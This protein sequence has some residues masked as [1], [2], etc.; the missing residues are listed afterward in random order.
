VRITA[1]LINAS[2]GYHLWSATY[3]R[4]LSDILSVQDD[5]ARAITGALTHELEDGGHVP[6]PHTRRKIDPAVY[7]L[8]LQG[9]TAFASGN[10]WQKAYTLFKEV[11]RKQP[12]FAPAY[13][14]LADS[15]W[16]FTLLDP[17]HTNAY[18]AEARS[19]AQTA[20]R[21]DPRNVMARGALLDVELDSWNWSKAAEY[22]S[23]LRNTNPDNA[24][25]AAFLRHYYE[26]MGF[27]D[28][29]IAER[30]RSLA[31]DPLSVETAMR[32][33]DL[34]NYADHYDEAVAVTRPVLAHNPDHLWALVNLCNAYAFEG[35]IKE[36]EAL[37][38]HLHRLKSGDEA[39]ECAFDISAN[40]KG[41]SA[42]QSI[43]KKWTAAFPDSFPFASYLAE[44]CVYLGDFDRAA[45]WYER[46]YERR[47]SGFFRATYWVDGAKFRTT[48]RWKA[49][50][51][52]ELFKEWQAE[53]D[54][55]AA[56]LKVAG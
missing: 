47:E 38:E 9:L 17:A 43:V 27:P 36:A 49:L 33:A 1:Q 39:D 22:A 41:H 34:L 6:A 29:A 11:T 24:D 48:P 55:I 21:L 26:H 15:V 20:L 4:D 50:T 44:D 8:Y 28:E 40:S 19:A 3:D 46:A 45:E 18:I 10:A 16:G 13:A 37:A 2:D 32:L 23:S 30:R 56:G 14:S 12:D 31:L 35:R 25:A 52:K 42:A 5:L 51:Q 54:R 7:R 53:H